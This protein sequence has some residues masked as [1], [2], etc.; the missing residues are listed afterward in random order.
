[1]LGDIFIQL[2]ITV[3]VIGKWTVDH[4]IVDDSQGPDI[5]FGIVHL[6]AHHLWTHVEGCAESL[7]VN[8]RIT[9]FDKGCESEIDNN[10]LVP[11][12]DKDVVGFK[13]S[14]HDFVRD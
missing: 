14:V 4:L 5:W 1:M 8:D 7:G 13:I 6:S 2:A 10:N 9:F 3:A 11:V 12:I